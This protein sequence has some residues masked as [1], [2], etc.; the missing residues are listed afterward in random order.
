MGLYTVANS[1]GDALVSGGRLAVLGASA[2]AD[3]YGVIKMDKLTWTG[4]EIALKVGPGFAGHIELTS[5][6]F[7]GNYGVFAFDVTE[8]VESDGTFSEDFLVMSGATFSQEDLDKFVS[9]SIIE[10]SNGTKIDGAIIAFEMRNG[11]E[12]WASVSGAIPEP[13]AIAAIM[14]A[15][16]VGLAAWRRRR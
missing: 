14:G 15:L 16:A 2:E 8:A 10:L 12:L 5:F 1:V 7:S 4:G 9:E 13:A 3:I 11:T 6:D